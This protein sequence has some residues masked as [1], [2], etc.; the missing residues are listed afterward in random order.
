[1]RRDSLGRQTSDRTGAMLTAARVEHVVI[2]TT[3]AFA[4]RSCWLLI[5]K[6]GSM[7]KSRMLERT[8]QADRENMLI[9]MIIPVAPNEVSTVGIMSRSSPR[10]NVTAISNLRLSLRSARAPNP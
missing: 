5:A 10:T 7:A 8:V 6:R 2:D 9:G 3:V 1:M 4:L